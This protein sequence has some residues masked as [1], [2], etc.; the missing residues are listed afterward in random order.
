VA[1][2]ARP[3]RARTEQL[4]RRAH[5]EQQGEREHGEQEPRLRLAQCLEGVAGIG[6]LRQQDPHRHEGTQHGGERPG[7]DPFQLGQ[8]DGRRSCHIRD[9]L[10]QV[11]Q[12]RL[13]PAQ[14][15]WLSRLRASGCRYGSAWASSSRPSAASAVRTA[16]SEP[17]HQ[18]HR[19][20][21]LG[22]ITGE[23][24]GRAVDLGLVEAHQPD[25]PARVDQGDLG[26]KGSMGDPAAD[27]GQR[28][29]SRTGG[30]RRQ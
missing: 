30:G 11:L 25:A 4:E 26:A 2:N 7:R 28:R 17:G 23:V 10:T 15:R 13:L 22:H 24:R 18:R 1:K 5:V 6:Q 8:L 12:E 29:R 27:E 20:Q 9:P 19:C 14:R 3:H 16:R 21:R